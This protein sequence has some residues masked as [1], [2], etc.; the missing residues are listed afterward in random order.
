MYHNGLRLRLIR[1]RHMWHL[2]IVSERISLLM[3]LEFSSS[4][5]RRPRIVLLRRREQLLILRLEGSSFQWLTTIIQNTNGIRCQMTAL[6]CTG[7]LGTWLD[8]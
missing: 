7:S 3:S 1:R 2:K 5:R 8:G 6:P 4:T